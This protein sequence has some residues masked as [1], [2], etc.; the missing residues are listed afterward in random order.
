M[1]DQAI[2]LLNH[3]AVEAISK[4]YP[5]NVF[6]PVTGITWTSQTRFRIRCDAS[7][8]DDAV[9]IDDVYIKSC[10]NYPAM[11]SSIEIIEPAASNDHPVLNI[12]PEDVLI[13]PNPANE[14]IILSGMSFR[15]ATIDVFNASGSMMRVVQSK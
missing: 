14:K 10:Q 9:Y 7:A 2:P 12:D 15:D 3:G 13:M 4:Q 8:N 11:Q 6:V 1:E 5:Y